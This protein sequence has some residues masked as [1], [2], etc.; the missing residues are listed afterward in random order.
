[1]FISF[2]FALKGMASLPVE[3]MRHGGLYWFADLT[4]PDPYYILPIITAGSLSLILQLGIDGPK[5]ANMGMVK[6]IL[7][8]LPIIILPVTITFPGV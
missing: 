7:Q 6:Y 1:M 8:A 4:V 3:S 2:F 5:L